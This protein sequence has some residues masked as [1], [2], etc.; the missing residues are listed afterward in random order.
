MLYTTPVDD[1]ADA[2]PS[3]E[4]LKNRVLVKAKRLPPGKTQDDD[5]EDEDEN[6]EEDERDEKKKKTAKVLILTTQYLVYLS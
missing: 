6:D 3:P 2:M 1:Q 5:I 4:S